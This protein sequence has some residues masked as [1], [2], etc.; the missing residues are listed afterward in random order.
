M[1][2]EDEQCSLCINKCEYDRWI[3]ILGQFPKLTQQSQM[4]ALLEQLEQANQVQI[5]QEA[6]APQWF[7]KAQWQ[8]LAALKMQFRPQSNDQLEAELAHLRAENAQLRQAQAQLEVLKRF[9][10]NASTQEASTQPLI[11]APKGS[12]VDRASRIFEA[13]KRWNLKHPNQ[14]FAITAN[15]LERDFGIHRNASKQFLN[16]NQNAIDQHHAS[17][18]IQKTQSHN[19]IGIRNVD[20]LKAFVHQ[21]FSINF[22]SSR[23]PS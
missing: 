13:I 4:S 6:Q 9:L 22:A 10:S 11:S 15:L 19:R 20:A 17:I 3:A 23:S 5:R 18:G 12:A 1:T 8:E 7:S 21:Q 14:T 2:P 16:V